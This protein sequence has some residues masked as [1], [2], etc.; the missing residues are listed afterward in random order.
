MP[1][2]TV[3]VLGEIDTSKE[4]APTLHHYPYDRLESDRVDSCIRLIAEPPLSDEE[5]DSAQRRP[6]L[7]S[8][9]R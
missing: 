8:G 6:P 9:G 5:L 4:E 3:E 2:R 7:A 1:L